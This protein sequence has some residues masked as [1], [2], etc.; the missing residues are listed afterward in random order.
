MFEHQS[1]DSDVTW[2]RGR[3]P[4]LRAVARASGPS[5]TRA[6]TGSLSF[7]QFI[8]FNISKKASAHVPDFRIN[9]IV[10]KKYT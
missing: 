9:L 1:D 7:A 6:Q 2:W 4:R 5:C 8:A 10:N 3:G